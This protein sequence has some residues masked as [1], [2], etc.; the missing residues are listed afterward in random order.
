MTT[1]FLS[2]LRRGSLA[3]A[4]IAMAGAAVAQTPGAAAPGAG[5]TGSETQL[6]SSAN[7]VVYGATPILTAVVTARRA[8]FDGTVTFYDG[9]AV[10]GTTRLAARGREGIAILPAPGLAAGTHAITAAYSGDRLNAGSTSSALSL[11]VNQ[12][13]STTAISASPNPGTFGQGVTLSATVGG[14]GSGRTGSVT[15][16]DGGTALGSAAIGSTGAAS[17]NLPGLAVGTHTLT[18]SYGGDANHQA[19]TSAA[20]TETIGKA[21]TT[22]TF[23]SANNPATFGDAVTFTATVSGPAPTG[24]V[25]FAEGSTVIGSAPVNNGAATLTV[26]ALASGNHT[27]VAS[28][29]GDANQ[30]ASTSAAITQVVNRASTA[31]TLASSAN[32]AAPGQGVTLTATVSGPSPTGTVTF[33]DGATVLGTGSLTGTGSTR[34]A[35]FIPGSWA[36][37]AHAVTAQY[38]GDANHASSGSAPLAQVVQSA[39]VVTIA[40]AANPATYGQSLVLTATVSGYQPGGSVSFSDGTNALG[41]APLVVAGNTATATLTV[42]NVAVGD[43]RIVAS[44]AG[45]TY[46]ARSSSASLAQTV[47]AAPTSTSIAAS[48]NPSTYGQAVTFSVQVTGGANAT[49]SVTFRDGAATLGTATLANGSASFAVTSLA[50][51]THNV[52]AVYGGDGNNAPSTSDALVQTVAPAATTIALAS[53]TNPSAYGQNVTWTATVSGADPGGTVS[54][55]DGGT[56]L[57][58]ATV[59]NGVATFASSS[60]APGAH[61]IVASYAGDTNHAAS[62]SATLRQDVNQASTTTTVVSNLNPAPFGQGVTFTATVQGA[63][64][65]GSVT[66]S[67]GAATLGSVPVAD[68]SA[69]ITTSALATGAHAITASYSGDAN[70]TASTSQ[71]V[72]ETING[73]TTTAVTANPASANVGANVTLAATVTGVGSGVPTGVVTF[74]EG[75]TVLGQ[76][77]LA[78]GSGSIVVSTLTAG[79]HSITAAYGGDANNPASSGSTTVTITRARGPFVWQYGYDAMGRMNMAVD[80]NGQKTSFYYDSLGRRIQTQ[81]PPNTGSSTPTVTQFGYDALDGLTSVVDPRNLTTTYTRDGL[82][83]S[84]AQNSP[85]TGSSQFTYDA[86]GNVLTS[87]DARG[88]VTTFTYDASNR[89]TN[90][91]YTSGTPTTFE[92]DGGANPT[93]AAVGQITTMTDESGQTG[94]SY[95]ALGRMTG[96]TVTIAGR[97]FTVGYAWGESGSALDKLTG[98]T[99]P[100]GTQVVYSYDA[101]GSVSAITVNPVNATGQGPSGTTISLLS[102][103]SYTAD[104]QVSGWSWSDGKARTIT[105]DSTG[106]VASYNLGDPAGSGLLRTIQRDSA[107]RITAYVHTGNGASA[108]AFD[109]TFAYDNLDR[110]TNATQGNTSTQYSYDDNGNRIAKTIG[111][112]A[113]PNMIS[114]TSNRLNQVRDAAG[115]ATIAHDA[116]GNVVGDGSFTYTYSDRGRM[117]GVTTGGGSVAYLYNGLEQRVKKS[118]PA[119]LVTSG[120]A[121][122]VYDEDGK[123]LGE[124]DADGNPVYETV[125]LGSMPVGALKQTGKPATSDIAVS[126]YNVYSDHIDTPRVITKQD[127]TIVWRWDAAEAFGATAPDQNPT[128]QGVFVYNQRFP[129]QVFD[130][131]TGLFQN[132]NRE[133]HAPWGR[134]VQ[135]DPIGLEGGL[136]TFSY[137][138]N[139]PTRYVDPQGLQSIAACAN[140]ANA[141][142]CAEAGIGAGAGTGAA[143][144]ARL[145]SLVRNLAQAAAAA[146]ESD[147]E[148]CNDRCAKAKADAAAAFQILIGRLLDYLTGGSRG[149]DKG[150]LKAIRQFQSNL[151]ES[152]ERVERH[153]NPLPPQYPFWRA[154]ADLDVPKLF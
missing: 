117:A 18:A 71:A 45:D 39:S 137:S 65:T 123:L 124:Y 153:C 146:A 148:R 66:F 37:G 111:G 91:A 72:I 67:D 20:I 57:G 109:Q 151:K 61:D 1:A 93:P 75:A 145:I 120:A 58:S 79:S 24:T 34:T 141:A 9:T 30:S 128:G 15:F 88:K 136:N 10:I 76:A 115:T 80:P 14:P 17:L 101:F 19:S 86:N 16:Y 132:W 40:S 142:V 135:S 100:S 127:H 47:Q 41:T 6:V 90:I 28:Y 52:T 56:P 126:I 25:T 23:S 143:S 104:Q 134:Y 32:P 110:L 89:V 106:M 49:G 121:H 103:V 60:L 149:P 87:K 97:A 82:G 54:F 108:A 5:R 64:P 105:Y 7:P 13:P 116:A 62:T 119:A 46:N 99:Y 69:S 73:S 31:T 8:L 26:T 150:H 152:L 95:D 21:G 48:V 2:F 11:V 63:N 131:E 29:S 43:H 78:D 33:L 85:D 77:T 68:G 107:G 144:A 130:A 12:A 129:G 84:R 92:Y 70:N 125:Y 140:P 50:A 98:I 113:Y 3:L 154:A 133:Y 55:S 74:S 44:Y 42:N 112:T 35:M 53:A 59:T 102:G 51:G 114:P 81:Q 22:T 36:P 139:Q 118:G 38:A 27:I 94:Y 138:F 147:K 122:Y 83:Q 96:K 4:F